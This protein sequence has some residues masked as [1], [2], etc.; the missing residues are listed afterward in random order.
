M[1]SPSGDLLATTGD[2]NCTKVPRLTALDG[3]L[4][5]RRVEDPLAALRVPED[6]RRVAPPCGV[7]G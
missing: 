2:G 7:E 5:G 3:D 6:D 1:D 4:P